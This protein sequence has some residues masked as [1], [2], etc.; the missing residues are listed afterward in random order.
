MSTTLTHSP[1]QPEKLE[2]LPE[3][4][5]LVAPR[6]P[7]PDM[8]QVVPPMIYVQKSVQ[9][10]YKLLTRNLAKEA[11]PTEAELNSLGKEGWELV[12]VTTDAPFVYFYFKRLAA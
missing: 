3:L 7:L 5:P 12:G 10:E 4:P 6:T 8:P 2:Q 9:W 11:T 1:I